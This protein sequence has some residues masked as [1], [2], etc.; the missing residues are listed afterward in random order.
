[1]PQ[2]PNNQITS[3]LSLLAGRRP[4]Q[5]WTQWRGARRDG[6]ADA[7]GLPAMLPAELPKPVWATEVGIGYAPPVLANGRVVIT[8]RDVAKGLEVARG[9]D[10]STGKEAWSISWPSDFVPPDPT[11]GRG[12]NSSPLLDGD[13]VYTLGLGGMFHCLDLKT[14]KVRWKHDF[15]AEFWAN[16]VDDDGSNPDFPVCGMAT[17]PMLEGETVIVPVGG[18]KAGAFAAFH[19]ETGKLVWGVLPERSS[20]GSPL[21][22]TVAGVRHLIGFT[23]LRMVGVALDRVNKPADPKKPDIPPVAGDSCLLWEHPFPAGYQQTILTPA[24]WKDRVVIGGEARPTL[25]LSF[26][27]EGARLIPSTTWSNP[28]LRAY[29]TS[30]VVVGDRLYGLSAISRYLV[31]IDMAT[32]KTVWVSPR[33]G[34]HGALLAAGNRLFALNTDGTL[35]VVRTD[36][37]RY[38]ALAE[39]K[40]GNR[41]DTW[42]PPVLT[43]GSLYLRV[44]SELRRYN[45]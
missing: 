12:P 45:L 19:R 31:C 11:A 8:G 24:L 32:G 36:T 13:R 1:M 6:I 16:T 41:N 15:R 5:E 14:G 37:D 26:R 38:E 27:R 2:L 18:A 25:A 40:I 23:G 35:T 30:P 22:G 3:L 39:W 4:N 33:I 42:T 9:L 34:A 10:V 21:I 29:T 28:E 43:S 17:S 44:G 20:Y 7:E